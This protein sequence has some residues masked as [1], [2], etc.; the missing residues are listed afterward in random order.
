MKQPGPGNTLA[1]IPGPMVG[2]EAM[3]IEDIGIYELGAG[4]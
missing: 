1:A 3:G 2:I 4:G